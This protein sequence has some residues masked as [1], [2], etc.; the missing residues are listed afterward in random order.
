MVPVKGGRLFL[1]ILESPKAYGAEGRGAFGGPSSSADHDLWGG[2]FMEIGKVAFNFGLIH[3]DFQIAD[4]A[5]RLRPFDRDAAADRIIKGH[6]K[7]GR[8]SALGVNPHR[9]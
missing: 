9:A 7:R 8:C 3:E 4:P 2:Q 5:A 1:G 6:G